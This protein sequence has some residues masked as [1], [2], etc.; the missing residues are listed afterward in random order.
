MARIRSIKPSFFTSLDIA[1][2][3]D[4]STRLHFVGLWTYVDDAGRG[5]DDARLIKAALWPLDDSKTTR[6]IEKMMQALAYAGRIE[7]YE[8]DYQGYFAVVGWTHQRIDKPQPTKF[9]PPPSDPRTIPEPSPN[10]PGTVEERSRPD[11]IGEERK[12]EEGDGI[13]TLSSSSSDSRPAPPSSEDDDDG[14]KVDT[15]TVAVEAAVEAQLRDRMRPQVVAKEGTIAD[16]EAWKAS[17]RARTLAALATGDRSVL[18]PFAVGFAG[19]RP[20][21]PLEATAAAARALAERNDRRLRGEP[22]CGKCADEG[23]I[24]TEGGAVERCSCATSRASA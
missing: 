12:G 14:P 11:R 9:P 1:R 20:P 22:L 6:K 3:P 23:W 2:L 21:D 19:G 17:A 15:D 18:E 5:I 10:D 13:G 8:V 7:R 24:E 16:V 4:D